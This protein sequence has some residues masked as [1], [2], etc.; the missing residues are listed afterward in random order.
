MEAGRRTAQVR[1]ANGGGL[2]EYQNR[3]SPSR[4]TG[5]NEPCFGP[6]EP[7][8]ESTAPDGDDAVIGEVRGVYGVISGHKPIDPDKDW[9]DVEVFLPERALPL[10]RDDGD[11][12]DIRRLLLRALREGSVPEAF[13]VEVCCEGDGSR[14]EEAERLL[15]FVLSDLGASTD[16]RDESDRAPHELGETFEEEPV[17]SE[18]L[19][20]LE[21]LASGRNE[22]LRLYFRGF[23]GGLLKADE[24]IALGRAMEEA[25]E[26]ALDALAAWPVGV[27]AVIEAGRRV[28]CGDA[29]VESYSS[30]PEPSDDGDQATQVYEPDDDTLELDREASAFVAAVGEIEA[31]IGERARLR[32]ALASANMSRGF[33][34]ELANTASNQGAGLDFASALTRQAAAR[35]RMILS[36]LRLVFSIAKK[37]MRSGEPLEDLVQEGNIGL[38]KA[39]ERYDWRKGFRFST[40]A[41]WWIRQQISRAIADKS[42]TVRIP[43]HMYET[44]R[45][46][47]R[48]RDEFEARAGQPE[49]LEET[50]RRLGITVSKARRI[51]ELSEDT[52]SLDELDTDT[53]LPFGELLPGPE[54]GDPYLRA[55]EASLR[56]TLLGMIDELKE[57]EGEIIILRFG[58]DDEGPMTLEEVGQRFEV[59]RERIRQIEAKALSK[60]SHRSRKE[61]LAPYLG[62]RCELKWGRPTLS[63]SGE[64][65]RT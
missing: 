31:S 62:E 11:G 44:V 52:V 30:G 16:E 37:Y 1:A 39:V 13:F 24:E 59:T 51:I 54:S 33:L 22:P 10:T 38:M 7:E 43:V 60:L 12:P 5:A 29:D 15:S 34:L 14:N 21:E 42:R 48:E 19:E 36:N 64:H 26:A 18:A 57:Q 41:T 58:F 25:G 3:T 27:A 17:I 61:I 20:Y 53:G 56:S 55:E 46:T 47:E 8:I 50:A 35:T 4:Y 40:Y 23:K 65:R 28:A 32:A 49:K 9:G 6:W 45:R 63:P 2:P